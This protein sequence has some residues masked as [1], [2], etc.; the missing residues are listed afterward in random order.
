MDS[1]LEKLLK[2]FLGVVIFFCWAGNLSFVQFT[3]LVIWTSVVVW[4]QFERGGLQDIPQ[5]YY[6]LEDVADEFEAHDQVQIAVVR[7]S[8]AAEMDDEVVS[9]SSL[10]KGKLWKMPENFKFTFNPASPQVVFPYLMSK[11]RFRGSE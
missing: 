11:A 5:K 4:T 2:N 9:P 3:G 7:N 6:S 8:T 10:R 1:L